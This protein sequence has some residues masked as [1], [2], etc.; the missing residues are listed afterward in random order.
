MQHM[1][2]TDILEVVLD[3]SGDPLTMSSFDNFDNGRINK[4]KKS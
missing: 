3:K 4:Y 2:Q 1:I